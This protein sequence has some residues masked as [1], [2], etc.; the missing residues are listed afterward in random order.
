MPLYVISQVEWYTTLL[1]RGPESAMGHRL[2]NTIGTSA[3]RPFRKSHRGIQV[4][5]GGVASRHWGKHF[6]VTH[7]HADNPPSPNTAIFGGSQRVGKRFNRSLVRTKVWHG[8]LNRPRTLR[9]AERE[10]ENPGKGH[11]SSRAKPWYAPI[12]GLKEIWKWVVSK[13]Y[14]APVEGLFRQ[15]KWLLV[16]KL[17]EITGITAQVGSLTELKEP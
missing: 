11:F 3:S 6:Q 8:F 13:S 15:Q 5:A 17:R 16:P 12:P 10:W 2:P 7:G 4:D 14:V 1:S 9:T